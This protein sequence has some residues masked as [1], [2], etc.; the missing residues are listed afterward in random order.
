MEWPICVK[1]STKMW[2]NQSCCV[3]SFISAMVY[4]VIHDQLHLNPVFI[5]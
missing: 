5:V 1:P 4:A 2:L 3:R